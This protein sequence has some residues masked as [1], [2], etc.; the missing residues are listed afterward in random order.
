MMIVSVVVPAYNEAATV[1]AAVRRLRSVPLHLEVIAVN[2]A[3][4]DGTR[5]IR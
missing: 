1:E 2:D 5:A 4:T 3:S